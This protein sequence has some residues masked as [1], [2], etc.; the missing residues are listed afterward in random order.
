MSPEHN[1]RHAPGAR[2]VARPVPLGILLTTLVAALSVVVATAQPS[3]A[4]G[5]TVEAAAVVQPTPTQLSDRL[6]SLIGTSARAWNR[7]Q[8]KNGQ[9]KDPVRGAEGRYGVPMTAQAIIEEGLR[10]SEPAMVERGLRALKSQIHHPDDG[11]FNVG[12]EVLGLVDSITTNDRLLRGNATWRSLRA[13]LVAFVEKRYRRGM[14]SRSKKPSELMI[15]M[16]ASR[17]FHNLKLVAAA[18]SIDYKAAGFTTKP[19]AAKK[20]SA[21]QL[22]ASFKITTPAGKTTDVAGSERHLL[23]QAAREASRNALDSRWD[24]G[25]QGILSDPATAKNNNPLAYNTLS[26]MMLGHSIEAQHPRD[27]SATQ[28]A[29]F[30]RTTRAIVGY[31]A[32]SGQLSFIGRGQGQVWVPALALNALVIAATRSSSELWRNRYLTAATTLVGELETTYRP[33]LRLGLPLV[34]RLRGMTAKQVDYGGV[35]SYASYNMYEGLALYG[36]R[37]A[38]DLLRTQS[39]SQTP[40]EPDP[41]YDGG[42]REAFHTFTEPS[43]AR[44]ATVR[45]GDF[46]YAIHGGDALRDARYDFG[47]VAAE[48]QTAGGSWRSQVPHRP[49]VKSWTSS[50]GSIKIGRRTFLPVTHSLRTRADGSV[51]VRGGWTN[52]P[53]GRQAVDKNTTWTFTPLRG[54]ALRMTFKPRHTRTYRFTYWHDRRAKIGRTARKLTIRRPNGVTLRITFNRRVKI[55]RNKG[56]GHSAYEKSLRSSRVIMRAPRGRTVTITTRF[57]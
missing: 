55:R 5:E 41:Q 19:P 15:C 46:W 36:L 35:D 3:A 44:F 31:M 30:E 51:V 49:M 18:A 8:V 23:D 39:W 45:K 4:A 13:P 34:P 14:T 29:A 24:D 43:R 40:I 42:Y 9:L 7:R 22:R 53:G 11:G 33:D 25:L 47:L 16:T 54:G 20:S 6:V 27:V 28:L 50:G 21:P 26:A 38:R 48:R 57:S 52:R 32:P 2:T 17:C 56:V 1:A 12:F 37:K 10:R